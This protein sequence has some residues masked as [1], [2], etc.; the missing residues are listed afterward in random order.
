MY[1][2][3][4]PVASRIA[5]TAYTPAIWDDQLWIGNLIASDESAAAGASVAAGAAVVAAAAAAAAVVAG[6][7]AGAS[8]SDP[9]AEATI[10]IAA[11]MTMNRFNMKNFPSVSSEG[12]MP[13]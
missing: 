4:L 13:P 8:S 12:A 6:A 11:R 7:A 10:A 2:T 3:E 5:P 9:Q 1:S